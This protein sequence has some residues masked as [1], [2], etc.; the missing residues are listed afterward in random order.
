[1][2]RHRINSNNNNN[3]IINNNQSIL[4]F[5]MKTKFITNTNLKIRNQNHFKHLTN[6]KFSF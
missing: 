3:I 1:M 6:M 2:T 4:Y 5:I